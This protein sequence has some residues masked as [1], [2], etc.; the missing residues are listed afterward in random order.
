MTATTSHEALQS[1]YALHA[2][3]YDATRWSFLFGRE[4][5][6]RLAGEHCQ[7][8]RILEVGC[9]TGRNLSSLKKRFCDASITGIDLSA[10]MIQV[11]RGKTDGIELIQRAYDSP[12]G[13]FDLILFSYALSMFN[14]GWE[15][16]I[17]TAAADLRPGGIVAV[18]DFSHT[19]VRWF[20]HWMRRNHVRMQAHL[21]PVLRTA[22]QPLKETLQPA[23]GGL[24]HYGLFI[25]GKKPAMAH[26]SDGCE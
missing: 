19:Q 22:F 14:P 6:L 18:V 2:R 21:W 15:R 20:E 9:G 24:W 10:D 11:A 1:Y 25:G 13:G 23:Y 16:S 5:I 26:A 8:K 4:A 17:E 12:A 3:I 7:P